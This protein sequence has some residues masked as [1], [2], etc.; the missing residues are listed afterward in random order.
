[1]KASHAFDLADVPAQEDRQAA[2]QINSGDHAATL[3]AEAIAEV[4]HVRRMA[5]APKPHL[6]GRITTR[7]FAVSCL[8]H[9]GAAK[10][11]FDWSIIRR[12][13]SEPFPF[14]SH[15][16]TGSSRDSRAEALVVTLM[17]FSSAIDEE[18]AIA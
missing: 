17:F 15:F 16:S 8:R 3:D 9:A 11:C 4:R 18:I 6:R 7:G 5:L 10:S 2:E 14:G 1:M 12:R 13:I